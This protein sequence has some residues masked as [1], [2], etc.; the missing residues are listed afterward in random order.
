MEDKE[1]DWN[2]NKRRRESYVYCIA[3][4][5]TQKVKGFSLEV[6]RLACTLCLDIIFDSRHSVLSS[7]HLL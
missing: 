2:T 7:N 1:N 3:S 6:C 4:K 5:A